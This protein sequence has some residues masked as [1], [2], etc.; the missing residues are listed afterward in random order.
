MMPL[1][2][3]PP[4]V[5]Q[6]AQHYQDLF[7]PEQLEHFKRYLTGLFVSEN[8]TIQAINGLFVVH[9]RNQSSLNRFFTEYWWSTTAVNER[10]LHVLG[11]DP[12]TR[13]KKHAVL[14]IDDTH[15]EKYGHHFPLLGKWFIPSAD[16]YGLSHN[17]VTIHYADRHE[18]YPLDLRWYAQMDIEQTVHWLEHHDIKYRPDVLARKKKESQKRKYLG[19]ILKRVRSA[20]PD[21][22]VPY[23]SKL[24]LACQ[25][26]DW[27]VAKGYTYPVVFD[28]WYTCKQVWHHIA[29]KGMI[30]VG[31]VE[32][33]DGVYLKGQWVSLKQWHKQLPERA[34]QP[35]R[36][37]YR[38]RQR[39]EHSQAAAE[40]RQVDQLGRVRL[41]AS[42]QEKDRSDEPRLYVCNYLQWELRYRLRRR[43]WRWPIEPS[44]E[45][46]KGPWGFDAY[47]LRDQKAIRRHW[48]RV[49]AAY[50]A[51]R[52]A[53]AQGRWGNW[54]KTNLKTVGDVSG[55]VPGEALAAWITF[56]LMELTQGR[57]VEAIINQ[58][59]SYLSR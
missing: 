18:D 43:P 6:Y 52:Q 59:V 30:D 3:I 50:S 37:R 39:L 33:D 53:P 38:T 15:N 47:E 40:T 36:F 49:V 14:I 17:V 27:A 31:T 41:V 9:T 24:D 26:I 20:H 1:V 13:P 25:L 28:S 7:S 54:I 10:R 44:Y 58:L 23:P 16:R 51:A 4:F 19:D 46:T 42:P 57:P 12:A 34:F 29:Q 2:E 45:D 8:K 56:V 21:W 5:D 55:Q 32:P 35:V 48:N 22:E 11:Q